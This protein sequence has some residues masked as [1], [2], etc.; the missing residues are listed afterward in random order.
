MLQTRYAM[1]FFRDQPDVL[2]IKVG[3]NWNI[4]VYS[5]D[6]KARLTVAVG[7]EMIDY[8][9]CSTYGDMWDSSSQGNHG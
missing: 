9:A 8:T 5:L 1:F 7:D 6:V 4:G 3:L 2:Y